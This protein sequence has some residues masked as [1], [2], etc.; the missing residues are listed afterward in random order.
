M[1]KARGDEP[2]PPTGPG[3]RGGVPMAGEGAY[4]QKGGEAMQDTLDWID[5]GLLI[6]EREAERNEPNPPPK[7]GQRDGDR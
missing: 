6:S 4:M 2:E 3:E 5:K 1:P 7:P